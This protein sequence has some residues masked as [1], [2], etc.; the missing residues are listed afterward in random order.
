[1]KN[2]LIDDYPSALHGAGKINRK[3]LVVSLAALAVLSAG[4]KWFQG[5]TYVFVWRTDGLRVVYPVDR[6]GEGRNMSSLF[7]VNGKA[8]GQLFIKIAVSPEGEGWIEY[9]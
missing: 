4:T 5:E 9:S 8:I 6:S 3:T 1:L 7:D 2:C